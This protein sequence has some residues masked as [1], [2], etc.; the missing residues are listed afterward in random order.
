M[1]DLGALLVGGLVHGT[2]EGGAA[3]LEGA[4]RDVVLEELLVDDVDDGGDQ[5]LDVLGA[6]GEGFDVICS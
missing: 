2:L 6:R 3:R 5:G 4:R 1:E